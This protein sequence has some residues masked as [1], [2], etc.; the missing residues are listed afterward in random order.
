MTLRR[1]LA[2]AETQIG[3]EYPAVD[4]QPAMTDEEHTAERWRRIQALF[5]LCESGRAT[6][7][8]QNRARVIQYVLD[9]ARAREQGLSS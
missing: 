3:R 8:E 9:R 6:P 4:Q 2:H 7:E 5:E 1:R